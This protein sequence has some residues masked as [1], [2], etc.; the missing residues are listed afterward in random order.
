MNKCDNFRRN[1]A[2]ITVEDQI[3][4]QYKAIQARIDELEPGKRRQ[5][6]D[7]LSKYAYNSNYCT[8]FFF[9]FFTILA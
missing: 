5:Y 4:G 7:L 6:K 9:F 8:F 3:D 2:N 1:I